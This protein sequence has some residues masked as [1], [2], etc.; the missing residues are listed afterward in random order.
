MSSLTQALVFSLVSVSAAA[1][2]GNVP[3][4]DEWHSSL[5]Q[6]VSKRQ[7]KA[8]EQRA[9]LEQSSHF[10]PESFHSQDGQDKWL[11]ENI[12]E[13]MGVRASDPDKHYFI[14]FGARDGLFLSNSFFFENK[15]KWDGVLI[16]PGL[17]D[18][19][20]LSKNRWCHLG[21]LQKNACI[22]SAVTDREGEQLHFQGEHKISNSRQVTAEST[23]TAVKTTTLNA[24]VRDFRLP[25][26]DLLSADCEGCELAALRAFDFSIPVS[27]I[28]V[29][30]NNLCEI[31][32]LLRGKGFLN[33]R[34]PFSADEVFVH[35]DVAKRIPEPSMIAAGSGCEEDYFWTDWP[36]T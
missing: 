9:Y 22:H 15:L 32:E 23:G 30:K 13:P 12:F 11:W 19:A 10:P 3:C 31:K 2:I 26:I 24:I 18:M 35:Q 7:G 36:G 14:E 17:D 5:L 4:A 27:V 28:L 29:E 33:I 21:T 25:R 34:L 6:V 16:E 1:S 20:T 8:S